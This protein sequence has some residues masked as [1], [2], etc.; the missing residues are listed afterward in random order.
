[1]FGI[2]FAVLLMHYMSVVNNEYSLPLKLTQL[3]TGSVYIYNPSGY[4]TQFEQ[5]LRQY[6]QDSGLNAKTLVVRE[7]FTMN[8]GNLSSNIMFIIRFR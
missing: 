4:D 5:H 7:N 6:I 2:V 3:H 8:E 1:M